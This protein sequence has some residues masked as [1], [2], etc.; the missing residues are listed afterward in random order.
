MVGQRGQKM[1]VN[2]AYI[3]KR[4]HPKTEK[5]PKG[6]VTYRVRIRM[7]GAPEMSESFPQ[8]RQ[9]IEWGLRMES[10]IKAG[11]YF[12][13]EE[14]K[15][16]TFGEFIDR[17]IAIELPKNPRAFVK[18]KMQLTWWRDQLKEYFLCHVTPSMLAGLKDKLLS[19]QTPR[20][21]ARSPS[22]ANRYFA[23]LSKAFTVGVKEWGWLKENPLLKVS[24][25][26]EG[27]PRDRYLSKE[28]ITRL[29]SVCKSS[30]S[31]YLFG[32]ALFAISTGARKGEIVNL[33]WKDIDFD[34]AT[35]TFH[36]TKNGENRTVSLDEKT[37]KHL[38]SDRSKRIVRS[39]Y[40]FPS[41]DG[42]RPADIRT[43]WEKAVKEAGL[44]DI[45]FHILR[46]TCASQLA[47]TGVS[48]LEIA[49][50]LGHK[51]LAMV[52]RYSHLSVAAQAR[53]LNK[54]NMEILSD[55][56]V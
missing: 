47:M 13:K 24:K 11:R 8:K 34:R 48:T 52:K 29:L 10:E 55:V 19:E 31:P 42:K 12:G 38:R 27:K 6:K 43:A 15:E 37:L 17:Y 22:T 25:F 20:G 44:E 2:M 21:T 39:E 30:K 1:E 14:Q 28:E 56:A 40:V 41:S 45:C 23:A 18:L 3:Q 49:D 50:V 7:K 5:N 33:K 51:T 16:R 32:I 26:K 35:A 54:M 36:D 53:V 46:H 4:V 9:A